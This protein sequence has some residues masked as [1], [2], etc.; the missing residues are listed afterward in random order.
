V[1][2]SPEGS[3]RH[4]EQFARLELPRHMQPARIQAHPALPRLPSGKYDMTAL[5]DGRC[6]DQPTYAVVRV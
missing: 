2:L 3:I 1:V 4:L 6:E 5:R